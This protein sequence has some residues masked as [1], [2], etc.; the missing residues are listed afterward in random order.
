MAH[1]SMNGCYCS[2]KNLLLKNRRSHL[3]GKQ[4]GFGISTTNEFNGISNRRNVYGGCRNL[5][6]RVLNCYG[7]DAKL[8]NLLMANQR[9]FNLFLT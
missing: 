9:N 1:Q 5:F 8:T 2:I 3:R 4:Q 7:Y 6:Q